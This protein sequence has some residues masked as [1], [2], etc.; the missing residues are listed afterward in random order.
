MYCYKKA[1]CACYLK[2]II[3]H[4]YYTDLVFLKNSFL[5]DFHKQ[6]VMCNV[7][8]SANT[9]YYPLMAIKHC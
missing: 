8:E 6:I 1:V 3:I 5:A 7:S 9:R 4:K 2:K